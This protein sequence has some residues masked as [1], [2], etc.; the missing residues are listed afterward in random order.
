[1]AIRQS[2]LGHSDARTTMLYTHEA[3]E[4]G[5]RIAARF[6]ELLDVLAH[7][8]DHA[9]RKRTIL[10]SNGAKFEWRRRA[11]DCKDWLWGGI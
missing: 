2:R 10:V 1:M 4:D 6:E 7:G 8:G 11:S 3:S 5:R 9:G